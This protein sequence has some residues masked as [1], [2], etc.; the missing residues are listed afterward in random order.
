MLKF[1]TLS[2]GHTSR[3]PQYKQRCATK[4]INKASS[5]A[6]RIYCRYC[7]PVSDMATDRVSTLQSDLTSED[8]LDTAVFAEVADYDHLTT[9]KDGKRK[10]WPFASLLPYA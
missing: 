8:V 7:A 4:C 9:S 2:A 1:P 3:Q 6:G 10:A 5:L